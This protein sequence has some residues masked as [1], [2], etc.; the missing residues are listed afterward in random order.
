MVFVLMS[1]VML[2]LNYIRNRRLIVTEE[3]IVFAHRWNERRI[4][5]ADI[6]W[7]HIGREAHVQTGGRFQVIVFK[8]KDRRRVYRI[9]VGRYERDRELVREMQHIADQVP[10]KRRRSWRRPKI[11]DR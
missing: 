9:R 4:P 3:A 5:I 8:L 6:E 10:H 1:L 11:M 7:M 2:W